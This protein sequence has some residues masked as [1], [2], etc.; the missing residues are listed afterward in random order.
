MYEGTSFMALKENKQ[1]QTKNNVL[2]AIELLD[3][4]KPKGVILKKDFKIRESGCTR[5]LLLQAT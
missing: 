4:E 5:M 1:I 3:I 2:N